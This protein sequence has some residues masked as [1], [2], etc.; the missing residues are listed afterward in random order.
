MY[1]DVRREKVIAQIAS[2]YTPTQQ[3]AYSALHDAAANY[4]NKHAIDEV[5]L[6]GTAR[7][8]FWIEDIEYSWDGFLRNLRAL[9]AN[10]LPPANTKAADQ[11]DARLAATYDRVLAEPSLRQRPPQ[12]F[13][14]RGF[15]S[16]EERSADRGSA[17]AL[18]FRE[19][20]AG[21]RSARQN[22]LGRAARDPAVVREALAG[23][24]DAIE[25]A[26][27]YGDIFEHAKPLNQPVGAS[28]GSCRDASN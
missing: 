15:L 17:P 9:E 12:E 6:S 28:G 19:H 2:S 11:A 26:F 18:Q 16:R 7:G 10:N 8:A 23:L 27:D 20:H 21:C 14:P 13:A 1:R 24:E 3:A 22:S 5:D 25:V 4:F